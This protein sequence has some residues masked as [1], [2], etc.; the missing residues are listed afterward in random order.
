M[1]QKAKPLMRIELKSN[2][3]AY[4]SRKQALARLPS[5]RRAFFCVDTIPP[6]LIYF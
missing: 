2:F 3:S 6:Y 5:A 4:Q 1:A